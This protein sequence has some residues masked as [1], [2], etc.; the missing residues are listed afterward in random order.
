MKKFKSA[1]SLLTAIV[2]VFAIMPGA[3]AKTAQIADAAISVFNADGTTTGILAD[4]KTTEI[5]RDDWY[6]THKEGAG[7]GGNAD[8]TA[9]S[10]NL[11]KVAKFTAEDSGIAWSWEN[12][13]SVK[14][15]DLWIHTDGGVKDYEIQTSNDGTTWNE[16]PVK[17]GTFAA[18]L[19][20]DLKTYDKNMKMACYYPI[21]L[22]NAVETKYI[23][24]VIKNFIDE[25]NTAYIAEAKVYNT[26]S[27]NFAETGH[28]DGN[29][30]NSP[31]L[32]G[33]TV[34]GIGN[35]VYEHQNNTSYTHARD[36]G[37]FLPHWGS[38]NSVAYPAADPNLDKIDEGIWYTTSFYRS[39]AK[40]N[41]IG[42]KAAGGTITEF[43]IWATNNIGGSCNWAGDPKYPLSINGLNWTRVAKV[44]C[45]LAPSDGMQYFDIPEAIEANGYMIRATEFDVKPSLV[46]SKYSPGTFIGGFEFYALADNE[47]SI[48]NAFEGVAVAENKASINI[49]DKITNNG[50]DYTVVWESDSEYLNVATGDI[51]PHDADEEITLKSTITVDGISYCSEKNFI[52]PAYENTLEIS[53]FN[54]DGTTAGIFADGYDSDILTNDYY[55]ATYESSNLT[56]KTPAAN[57]DKVAKFTTANSGLEFAWLAE[58]TFKRLDL[59]ILSFGGVKEY[60]IE[61]LENGSWTTVQEDEFLQY[62][63]ALADTATRASYYPIVF[64]RPVTTKNIRFVIKSFYDEKG[65]YISEA[66]LRE[67]NDVNLGVKNFYNLSSGGVRGVSPYLNGFANSESSAT[68]NYSGFTNSKNTGYAWPFY[69]SGSTRIYVEDDTTDEQGIWYSTT[70]D[71]SKVKVN[72]IG[73]NLSSGSVSQFKVYVHTS[74]DKGTFWTGNPPYLVEHYG[75][76]LVDTVDCNITSETDVLFEIPKA[77]EAC[78]ILIQIPEG[79]FT[80][81]TKIDSFDFYSVADYELTPE[82]SDAAAVATDGLVAG[83]DVTFSVFS[84]NNTKDADVF[85]ALY[86]GTQLIDIDKKDMPLSGVKTHTAKYTIPADTTETDLSVKAYMW[87]GTTLVPLLPSAVTATVPAAE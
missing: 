59:W 28:Y 52:L 41:R 10:A 84:C 15:I 64:D 71:R 34:S 38:T 50:K 69:S 6:Y 74:C 86:S 39:F 56:D 61:A 9:I 62:D 45:N 16:T 66:K 48:P 18:H 27:I 49:S 31:Y 78:A 29:A 35:N 70:F 65:A 46:D 20:G 72:K 32:W 17:S 54:G 42:F 63:V 24:F 79:Q 40:I 36:G 7:L 1:L 43:E 67:T 57:L 47:I 44:K 82:L 53:A 14:R 55:Y 60:K 73:I 76:T 80:E 21:I 87:D 13:V 4:G 26:N 58:K 25:T 37:R 77:Y 23:R 33:Y 68:K 2:M 30:A 19:E 83:K 3:M 51:A 81:G 5:L 8:V 11:D 85:F 12:P 22:D 75:Y